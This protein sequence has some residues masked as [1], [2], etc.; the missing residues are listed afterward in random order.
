MDGLLTPGAVLESSRPERGPYRGP[1]GM[2]AW[3]T[4]IDA[5]WDSFELNVHELRAGEH[6]VVALARIYSRT[7]GHVVDS[8]IAVL[9]E[10]EGER[11]ARIVICLDRAEALRAAGV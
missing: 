7:G 5:D 2:R 4:D 9:F 11:V 10:L 8:P 6:G 3:M 1:E